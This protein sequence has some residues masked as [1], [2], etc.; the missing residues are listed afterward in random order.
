MERTKEL[1]NARRLLTIHTQY[2][3]YNTVDTTH[4][5]QH[6][7]YNTVDITQ[8][9]QHSWYN[10]VD[11]IVDTIQLIQYSCYNTVDAIQLMQYSGCNTVDTIQLMQYSWCTYSPFWSGFNRIRMYLKSCLWS[12]SSCQH[13][14]IHL[15]MNSSHGSL[16]TSGRNALL[17]RMT[18]GSFT[19]SMISGGTM[20]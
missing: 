10:T 17:H 16:D 7:W 20:N 11:T 5:I 12:G 3:W 15:M 14:C 13:S 19:L 4:L 6:R 9:I 18:G 1:I 2:S 8:L